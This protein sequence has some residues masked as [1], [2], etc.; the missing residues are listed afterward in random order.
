MIG[1]LLALLAQRFVFRDAEVK[2][3]VVSGLIL[4]FAA[5]LMMITRTQQIVWHAAPLFVGFGIGIIGS[6][7]LLF[8]IKLSR[9]CQRGTSQ[10][11]F[12]LGWEGGIACGIGLG[13][14]LF[15]GETNTSLLMS[16]ALVIVALVMYH[17]THNWFVKNKNR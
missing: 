12:L 8:F 15:Q 5:L 3:E 10:S 17:F 7:F 2:S 9:H 13:L 14:T 11:T 1:F 16:L 4:L 6:R